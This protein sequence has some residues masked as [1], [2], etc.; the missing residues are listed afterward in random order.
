MQQFPDL[1]EILRDIDW[2]AVGAVAARA[3]MPE[4]TTQDLSLIHI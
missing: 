1:R 3:Y 2:V 4:R